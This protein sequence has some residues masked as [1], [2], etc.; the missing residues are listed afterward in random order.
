[1]EIRVLPGYG[2]GLV[3]NGRGHTKVQSNELWGWPAG[4]LAKGE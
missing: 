1:M 4:S 2:S 3:L